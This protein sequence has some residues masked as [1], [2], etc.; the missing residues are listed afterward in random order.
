MNVEMLDLTPL[1]LVATLAVSPALGEVGQKTQKAVVEQ[2]GEQHGASQ[3]SRIRQGVRQV[4]QR[5][6]PED[7]DDEAFADFCTK[8]FLSDPQRRT[9]AFLRLQDAVEQIDG[10]LHEVRRDLTSPMDLDTG[11]ISSVD[12]LLGS[13]DLA[14][15]VDEDLFR[16]KVAFLALLN[17]PVHSLATRLEHSARWDRATWARSRMTDRFALRVPA[18]VSQEIT[19]AFTEADQYIAAYNVRMDRLLSTS[20]ETAIENA[21]LDP[22]AG[23]EPDADRDLYFERAR[24]GV[25]DTRDTRATALSNYAFVGV[26]EKYSMVRTHEPLLPFDIVIQGSFPDLG[27]GAFPRLRGPRLTPD[28]ILYR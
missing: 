22:L 24:L 19:A 13:L 20:S 14:A 25:A 21:L 10:H 8:H 6:W 7:G 3:E 17:F 9:D 2:L 16:T 27:F 18:T 5:W 12:R 4:A 15:H 23:F 1:L 28:A 26:R 11:E